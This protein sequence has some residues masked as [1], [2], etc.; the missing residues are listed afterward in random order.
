ME[1]RQ[2]RHFIKVVEL[3]NFHRAADALHVTQ[4]ALSA[5]ISRL[6]ES[7]GVTLFERGPNGIA[8]TTFGEKLLERARLIC[9]ES[10]RVQQELRELQDA[11]TGVVRVGA[12]AFFLE[13]LLPAALCDY[14]RT[15]PRVQV[16]VVEGISHELFNL[17]LA[18][19]ID[20]SMSTPVAGLAPPPEIA[21]EVLFTMGAAVVMRAGHPLATGALSLEALSRHPW[22]VSAKYDGQLQKLKDVFA[23]GGVEPPAR[24]LR[25]DAIP[26]IRYLVTQDD[27]LM[28]S[29]RAPGDLQ[30]L[31]TGATVLR[32]VPELGGSTPA[33]LAWHRTSPMLP[34]ATRFMEHVRRAYRT[35]SATRAAS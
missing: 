25:T 6:E 30:V 28:V 4:Q 35:L 1:L 29:A 34:A 24:I 33:V 12:G 5:S 16:T 3:G 32:D 20:F 2:L 15:H 17:L 14:G 26:V 21:H 13:R 11:E 10:G 22:I 19:E 27:Y 7:V 23:K 8:L 18:G 9:A 31:P